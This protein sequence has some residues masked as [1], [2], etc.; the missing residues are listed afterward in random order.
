MNLKEQI[1]QQLKIIPQAVINGSLMNLVQWKEKVVK[2]QKMLKNS[3]PKRSD[4]EHMLD[5]LRQFQ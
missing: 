3:N 5:Q 4:L 1:T 2:A